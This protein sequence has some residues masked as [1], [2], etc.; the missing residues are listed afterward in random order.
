[1]WN[2]II[3]KKS[4]VNVI[5]NQVDKMKKC[6]IPL[7]KSGG[8]NKSDS[9]FNY[10]LLIMPFLSIFLSRVSIAETTCDIKN[11]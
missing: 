4:L 10:A 11:S 7:I 5:I 9:V 3:Y 8:Q 2:K 1:M 6:G